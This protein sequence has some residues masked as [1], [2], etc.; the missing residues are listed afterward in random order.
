MITDFSPE[1]MLSE[2]NEKMLLIWEPM[3]SENILEK[4]RPVMVGVGLRAGSKGIWEFFVLFTQ[5]CCDPKT[6]LFFLNEGKKYIFSD[7]KAERI[8]Q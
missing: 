1:I 6:A 4:Q 8:H 7:K 2:D 3:S 5:F